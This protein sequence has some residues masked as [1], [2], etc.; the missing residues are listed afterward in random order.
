VDPDLPVRLL[1]GQPLSDD[2]AAL[3]KKTDIPD[4]LQETR[5]P[6]PRTEIPLIDELIARHE[7]HTVRQD[8]AAVGAKGIRMARS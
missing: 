2:A 5:V 4:T 6:P 3:R 7:L 8:I 1:E